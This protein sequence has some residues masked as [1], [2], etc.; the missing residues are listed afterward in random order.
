M[1]VKMFLFH[2]TQYS[3]SSAILPHK[4]IYDNIIKSASSVT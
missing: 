4:L 1:K 3:F 2:M